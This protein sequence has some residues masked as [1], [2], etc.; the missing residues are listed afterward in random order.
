MLLVTGQAAAQA[1]TKESAETPP[2]ERKL[3]EAD[4][5]GVEEW[6]K[7]IGELREAGRFKEAQAAAQS[8]L[9]VRRRVQGADHWQTSD[10]QRLLGTLEKI[11]ALPAEAQAVVV[12]GHVA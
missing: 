7:K 10:A 11:A 8:I 4:A 3:A 5:K 12:A 1:A 9:E 6:E 2:Y